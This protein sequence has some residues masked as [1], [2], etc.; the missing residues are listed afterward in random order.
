[1]GIAPLFFWPIITSGLS[2]GAVALY[3]LGGAAYL[4]GI[5]FFLLGE[6]NPSFHVIWHLF[7]ALGAC[8]HWF[9]IYIFILNTDISVYTDMS[10]YT[11]ILTNLKNSTY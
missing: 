1:M 9:N 5:P 11:E 8:L 3:V 7:V 2:Y 10:G 4:I 6:V